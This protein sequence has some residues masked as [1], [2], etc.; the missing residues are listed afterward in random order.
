MH[1]VR[2]ISMISVAMATY[3]GARYLE[4]QLESIFAQTR[5][6]QEI[7]IY[8]D[9]SKDNTLSLLADI[10]V[11]A[12]FSVKVIPGK[13]NRGVNAAFGSALMQCSGEFVFFCDQDDIWEP[14][15]IARFMNC[16]EQNRNVGMVFCDAHQI[17]GNGQILKHSL[18]ESVRFTKKRRARFRHDPFDEMLRG[19][20]FVYG[21]ASAFRRAAIQPF[22][23]VQSDQRVMT[24]DTWFALHVLASGWTG[25]I[26]DERLVKYR[27]HDHQ[28]TAAH[29][30]ETANSKKDQFAALRCHTVALIG[31]LELIRCGVAEVSSGRSEPVCTKPLQQ[32]S[33]KIAHLS[34]RQRLRDSRSLVL[35]LRAA[36]SPG[37]S[38]YAKGPLS[39]LR[40]LSGL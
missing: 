34:L 7:I 20:N 25:A 14:E 35:A 22:H 1:K 26:L 24:H 11:R 15:K 33:E 17:N 19:G 39:V 40:D 28:T 16:F 2:R 23:P 30:L 6:P 10:Q 32:L 18:W 27:R 29:G 3:N 38:K 9:A 21:M 4:E 5:R 13:V 37:Y 36:T 31:A 8:D 12:P